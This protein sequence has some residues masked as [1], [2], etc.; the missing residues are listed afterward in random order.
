[1]PG[2]TLLSEAVL[3]SRVV[4]PPAVR[5]APIQVLEVAL[6]QASVVNPESRLPVLALERFGAEP[7]AQ[8]LAFLFRLQE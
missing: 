6:V 5:A 8:E 2:Q 4:G 3:A 1:M 7:P